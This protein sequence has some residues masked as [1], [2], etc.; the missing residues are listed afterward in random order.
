V[1]GLVAPD[2]GIGLG[3]GTS[4]AVALRYQHVMADR[5]GAIAAAL[6][7]LVR[8]AKNGNRPAGRAR[9]GH[10]SPRRGSGKGQQAH[11]LRW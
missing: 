7:E 10:D 4:P 8:E 9:R 2:V 5:Q 1:L 6:D 3:R 11:D